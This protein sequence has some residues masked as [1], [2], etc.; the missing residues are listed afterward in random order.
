M[1]LILYGDLLQSDILQF[2]YKKNMSGTQ[3]SWM[4]LEVVSYYFRHNT[5]VQAAYLDCTK[6]FDTCVFSTLFTKVLDRGVP[7]IVVRVLLKIY[8]THR[9]WVKWS[10]GQSVLHVFGISGTRQGSRVSPSIFAVYLDGLLCEL[11]DSGVGCH[12]GDVFVGVGAFA[13][14]LVLLAPSHDG[15]QQLLNITDDYARRY[16]L[17]FSVDDNPAPLSLC[18]CLLLWVDRADHL[19][20]VIHRSGSQD[21]NTARASYIGCLLYTSDAADE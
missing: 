12:V 1:I 5:T 9:C 3:C 19:G 4:V 16:N 6:T 11:R 7:A 20:H 21:Y 8:R 13:D 17:T 15:L 2:G 18:G 10:A 14:D